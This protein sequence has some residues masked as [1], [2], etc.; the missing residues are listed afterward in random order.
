VGTAEVR[1]ITVADPTRK[2]NRRRLSPSGRVILI[3][4]SRGGNG[5]IQTVSNSLTY[6]TLPTSGGALRVHPATDNPSVDIR[7]NLAEEIGTGDTTVGLSYLFRGEP[8][9]DGHAFI[10]LGTAPGIGKKWGS[11]FAFENDGSGLF[12]SSNETFFI[13]VRFDFGEG[14]DMYRWINPPL[15]PEPGAETAD[16]S[17]TADAGVGDEFLINIVERGPAPVRSATALVRSD[18]APVKSGGGRVG[19]PMGR[20][21]G[22]RPFAQCRHGSY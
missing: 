6:S 14:D 15:G 13:V 3:N 22:T 17:A 8:R 1:T 19:D 16:H 4:L 20:G 5:I 2:L 18:L 7:R 12:M 21:S 11:E 9:R 10:R